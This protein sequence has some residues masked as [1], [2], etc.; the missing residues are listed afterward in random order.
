MVERIGKQRHKD[1]CARKPAD[2]FDELSDKHDIKVGRRQEADKGAQRIQHKA[3]HRDVSFAEFLCQ[4][5]D[6]EDADSHRDA[7]EHRHER[8]RHTVVISAQNVVAVIDQPDVFERHADRVNKEIGDQ[9]QKILVA[10]NRFEL[11]N[12]GYFLLFLLADRFFGDPLF[13]KVVFDQRERQRDDRKDRHHEDPQIFVDAERRHDDHREDQRH[14]DAAD[15][16]GRDLIEDRQPASLRGVSR[17]KG[18]HQTVRHTVDRIGKGVEEV[19]G[20]QHPDRFEGV[21]SV[22]HDKEQNARDREQRCGE[23]QPGSGFTLLGFR[24]VDD[25]AHDDVRHRVNSF[26]DQRKHGK[27]QSAAD[28]RQV[29]NVRIVN[30]EVGRE[31]SVEQQSPDRTEQI[32]EPFF[33][34]GDVFGVYM[35]VKDS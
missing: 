13:G 9:Q 24:A 3:E 18:H 31:Y 21:A 4:R 5:P 14:D 27:E 15:H 26:G 6:D 25:V 1:V 23:Q 12:K 20:E 30:V 32:T 29:Q 7:A 35:T 28:G 16:D 17:R 19:I 11:Q 22:R 33:F 34:S 10:E 8:L 2:V